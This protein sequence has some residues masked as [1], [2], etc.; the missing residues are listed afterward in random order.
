MERGIF[1]LCVWIL[2]DIESYQTAL[3]DVSL[4]CF[5]KPHFISE[6]IIVALMVFAISHI[7][8]LL[9][10]ILIGHDQLNHVRR[11]AFQHRFP[12]FIPFKNQ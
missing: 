1:L 10:L 2:D 11:R 4:T 8:N 9:C 5:V 7:F 6:S 12:R 3:Y